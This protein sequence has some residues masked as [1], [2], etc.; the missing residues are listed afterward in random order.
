MAKLVI[1]NIGQILSGKLEDPIFDGDCLVAIDGKISEWGSEK[2]IDCE[3]ATTFVD[4]HGV[5]LAPGLID[6]HIHPVVGDY[7]PRQQ[8]LHWIDSTLHGGVTTLISA[9]EVHMPGRP[10]DIVG[11]KAMAIASQRWYE[12]FRPSGVKVHAGAPVIEHGM[13][14]EDF[15]DLADAGVKL[16]G[17]VGLGTVKDGKTAQQMVSWA[18]KYGI[19]STIHTGGPSI[20]GSGLIDADMVIETGTD[21]IGHI[22]GG[23]SALPD[24]Q[25]ICLCESCQSAFEIVH[26]GNERSAVLALNTARELDKL[27]QVILGTDGPA[28]SGVQPL[29]ILRMVAMLSAFGNVS[30]EK[31]FCFANGNTARQRELDTG[32]IEVGKCADFVLMDQAQ[33]SPGKNM[34]ES[35]QLGNLP[36]VGMTIIDGEVRTERSRNTPP[37]MRLPERVL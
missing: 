37:A 29:G 23:H 31:A 26:N 8:Q 10:K 28:G 2:D 20:P 34:L 9:G 11:L 33:H 22:N 12:N 36:G 21:V 19:Q 5:T 14:E 1:K 3:N 6:S 15:K 27:D 24:D 25:I 7:T 18:R 16:L 32:L 13:V 30:A 4:A 35:V 17:E